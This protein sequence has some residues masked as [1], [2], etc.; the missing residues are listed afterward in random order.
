MHSHV[1]KVM[2]M[3]V[4]VINNKLVRRRRSAHSCFNSANSE[5]SGTMLSGSLI[6]DLYLFAGGFGRSGP[7]W[8][9][10]DFFQDRIELRMLAA[11]FHGVGHQEVIH[12]LN[13]LVGAHFLL[14]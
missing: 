2:L 14:Q 6:S 7:A 12:L 9:G 10:A 11:V 8:F 3:M 5:E 4:S 13:V 1:A